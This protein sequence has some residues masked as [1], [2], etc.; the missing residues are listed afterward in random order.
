M[1]RA[2]TSDLPENLSQRE[3]EILALI[4]EG[5][6][7]REISQRLF[8]SP[9]TVKWYNKHLFR[10]LGVGSRTQAVKMASKAHWFEAD[11]PERQS[12]TLPI[13]NPLPAQ[14]TSYVGRDQDIAEIKKLLAVARLVVLTGAGG[15]GKTRL[16]LRVAQE[17]AAGYRQGV[18]WVDLSPVSSPERVIEVVAQ[19]L[20]VTPAGSLSTLEAIKKHLAQQHL[21]LLL[22]NFEH[23]L[24]A[25]PL[26]AELLASAPQLVVLATSREKLHLYGEVEYPV[27]PLSLPDLS[28]WQPPRQLLN[29]E[30]VDLFFQRA[31]AVLPA[32]QIH[33]AQIIAAAR[34]C[35]RLDGLPLAIELAASYVKIYSPSK[36]AQRLETSLS[37]LPEGPRDLPARQRTL[38]ATI[39][40]SYNLLQ[41]DEKRLISRMTVFHGG[42]TLEAVKLVCA[43]DLP[44]NLV[45]TIFALVDK[46]FLI[47]HEGPDGEPHFRLLETIREVVGEYLQA[48]EQRAWFQRQHA[49]YYATLAEQFDREIQTTRHIYWT[50][51]MQIEHNNLANAL[52]WA[53]A[54]ND[55]MLGM[56]LVAALDQYWDMY[57]SLQDVRWFEMALTEIQTAPLLLRAAVL[58]A[59][60]LF[61][62][63]WLNA[64]RAMA[65]LRQACD[66]YAALGDECSVAR[67]Q[68]IRI[69]NYGE[70]PDELNAG[71]DLAQ[72]SLDSLRRCGDSL[73][74][75]NAL[76]ALGEIS[77]IAGRFEAARAYNA[78]SLLISTEI[79]DRFHQ[80]V[81]DSNLSLIAYR[82]GQFVE[83]LEY[84]RHGLGIVKEMNIPSFSLLLFSLAGA[85]AALGEPLKAMRLAGAGQAQSEFFGSVYQSAD[86]QDLLLILDAIRR[87]GGT[88]PCQQAWQAGQAMSTKDVL[89]Y[90]LEISACMS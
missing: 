37:D 1:E 29:Y 27:K 48:G 31:R 61:Y 13:F 42:C 53:F 67:A 2:T 60:G 73:G 11:L 71:I 41:E 38:R 36:L 44:G 12:A 7:N 78:E 23:L 74:V 58:K 35:L 65:L 84:V 62:T 8:L 47:V 77:R 30:A 24:D 50:S 16:A 80:L 68:L 59:A 32:L 55:H 88:E 87:V 52:A 28:V 49:L 66:L 14:V 69:A 26:V 76:T 18:C 39:D 45:K 64:P 83:A 89:S 81:N 90:A 19:A 72:K 15:T 70:T 56:R 33:D 20:K 3:C 57:G 9:D 40:W 86:Q 51:R 10:K 79:G 5:L 17:L 82:L 6:S 54:G 63:R 43:S 34:I 21:L 46:N 4:S 75:A 85:L 22:D 25:A